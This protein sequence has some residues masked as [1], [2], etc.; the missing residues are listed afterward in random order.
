MEKKKTR[1]AVVGVGCTPRP[2][3]HH[4]E[5]SWKDLAADAVYEALADARMNARELDGC[6]CA[7][8]GESV[9]EQGGLGG[10]MSDALAIAPSSVFAVVGNC[11]GGTIGIV[12]AYNLIAS[13]MYKR[14][15]VVGGDKEG[16]NINYG[17]C[18]N[19]SYDT[20]YDYMFGFRHRD[21]GVLANSYMRRFGYSK[22]ETEE[23]YAAMAHQIHKF[24]RMNPKAS[25]YGT[26]CPTKESLK[27]PTALFTM[28]GE[29]SACVILTA[30]EEAYKYND[31]PVW[32]EG[33][34]YSNTSHYVGHRINEEP[35]GPE[36]PD[37]IDREDA[38]CFSIPGMIASRKAYEMAGITPEMI[39]VAQVYDLGH[40]A[41]LLTEALGL[42]PHGEAARCFKNGDFDLGGRCPVDTDGGNIA[43]G[44]S[45]G[46]D[47]IL[48]VIEN[49]IQLRGKAGERQVKDAK[50]AA[51]CNVGSVEAQVTAIIL[52]NDRYH[53]GNAQQN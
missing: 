10:A 36:F 31:N 29:G 13:G 6:C 20:E 24:A 32:I 1:V 41:I 44:H 3:H 19:I 43:R 7:Y 42:C 17:Q 14:V 46:A 49:V 8:H 27:G 47:G 35:M 53:E 9:S 48:Q 22:E 15:A 39:D 40:A 16:D 21:G 23:C 50:L 26:P 2:G 38:R 25:L 33:L 4:P 34:A 30:E 11:C 52:S 5:K 18:I 37:W 51:S 45:S 12:M 28:M